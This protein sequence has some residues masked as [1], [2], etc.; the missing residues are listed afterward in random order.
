MVV[1]H[2]WIGDKLY[3]VTGM[4]YEPK[5]IFEHNNLRINANTDPELTLALTT[6][7]LCN[8]A[9]LIETN[10]AWEI[11]GDP[12]EGALLA[13]AAKADLWK[14]QLEEQFPFV[15]EL[16]FDSERKR[17]TV[18]R[19]DGHL[20]MKGALE[21]TLQCCNQCLWHGK[22][23][24]LDIEKINNINEAQFKLTNLGYRVLALA[25]K[26]SSPQ[27]SID[28][29]METKFIFIG[30]VAMIDPP[31]PDVKEAIQICRNA[32]IIP[33][34]ITGDHKQT[35]S[36]IAQ[37]IGL[38][39]AKYHIALDG[40]DLDQMNDEELQ[41]VVFKT[42]VFSRVTA[43]HKLRI[44]QAWKSLGHVVAMTGDGVNDTLAMKHADIGIAMGITG[45]DVT[46]QIS[47]MIILDD[48]FSTIVTAIKEGRIIYNNIVKFIHFLL[49]ANFG[50]ILL[51][52]FGFL[53]EFSSDTRG[54]WAI[55][56]PSQILWI[57]LITDGCPA[58]ALAFDPIE[59]M[60]MLRAPRKLSEPILSRSWMAKLISIGC[61][62]ALGSICAAYLGFSISK[63]AGQTMA[64]SQLVILELAIL[65]LLRLPLSP[66]SNKWL[67][68]ATTASILL[69][70]CVIYYAPLQNPFGTV[71]LFAKEWVHILWISIAIITSTY[72]VIKL[73]IK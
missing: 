57:N 70:I 42:A 2:F 38:M 35:A 72:I 61:L 64:F 14:Q 66:I 9:Q 37:K 28:P 4:G 5:G 16:P 6:G 48:R 51:I 30:L 15:G 21:S 12:T 18:L 36:T 67:L 47:D 34:M 33:V 3:D 40:I 26:Q 71:F 49:S 32:K 27:S 41:R 11:I 7:C 8:D 45:T 10:H 17:M 43:A 69:Q 44:I 25:Y 55:L 22:I 13:A 52:I 54:F 39:D 31:R 73:R 60:T 56:L 53:L 19:E 65:F 1:L 58:I 63:S 20:Y 24:D 29:S 50:E 59:K 68:I 23:K 46:K 62:V